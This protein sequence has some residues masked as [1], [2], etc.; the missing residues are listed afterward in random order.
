MTKLIL[1]GYTFITSIF[2]TGLVAYFSTDGS[3]I[4]LG[5]I[6]TILVAATALIAF[7]REKISDYENN[8]KIKEKNGEIESLKLALKHKHT[9]LQSVKAK[10]I[11]V[12]MNVNDKDNFYVTIREFATLLNEN[13]AF[14][15]VDVDDEVSSSSYLEILSMNAK[16]KV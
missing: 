4:P 16:A 8:K 2:Y 6:A 5:F 9:M 1:I 13:P 11:H 14:N 7:G 12:V 15:N 10:V 3:D